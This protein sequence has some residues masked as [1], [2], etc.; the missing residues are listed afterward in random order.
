MTNTDVVPQKPLPA[1]ARFFFYG[2]HG[3]FDEI[4]FTALFDLFLEPHGNA[5]LKG[6]TTIYSFFIYGSCSLAVERLYV[7]LY[8]KHGIPW[9]TRTAIYLLVLYT[10]ELSFGL[11]LRQ[12][13]ACSWDYSHYDYNFMGLITLEYAPGWIVLCLWQDVIA[14]FLLSLSINVKSDENN[15]K[16][17]AA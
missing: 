8:L 6:Y 10:W 12:F 16:I 5:Q 3:L 4:V 7:Y 15:D 1:V 13:D 2:L 14:D 17:K 9:Y 11:V